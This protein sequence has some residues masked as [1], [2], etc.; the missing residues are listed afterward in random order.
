MRHA[1]KSK[2]P[3]SVARNSY[4][5]RTGKYRALDGKRDDLVIYDFG[6]MPAF[7]QKDRKSTRLNSSH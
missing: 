2:T 3:S 4:I 1:L 5:S 6:N 7:A